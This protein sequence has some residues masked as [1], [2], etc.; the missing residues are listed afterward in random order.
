MALVSSSGSSGRMAIVGLDLD[1]HVPRWLR[2][3][4][5]ELGCGPHAG[6]WN[7]AKTVGSAHSIIAQN[8]DRCQPHPQGP[9]GNCSW[10]LEKE[11][12]DPCPVSPRVELAKPA[13]GKQANALALLGPQLAK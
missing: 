1:V 2:Q 8:G 10:N 13:R 5:T 11:Q 6:L 12:R 3:R 9:R 4:E 7:S